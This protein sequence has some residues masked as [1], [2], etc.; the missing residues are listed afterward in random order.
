MAD[1]INI[2]VGYQDVI[3][4]DKASIKLA[5]AFTDMEKA[6]GR[7][8]TGIDGLLALA[9]K[10]ES[11]NLSL[12]QVYKSL[13]ADLNNAAKTSSKLETAYLQQNLASKS[14][15][16]SAKAMQEAFKEQESEAAKLA[17]EVENLSLKYKP[18]YAAS[19]QYETKL[20]E[21]NKAHQLGVISAKQH[22]AAIESLNKDYTAFVNGT[23]G[24]S[25]QFVQ[26][27]NRAG[28]SV[29]RFGMYAQQFGYQIGDFFVQIQS[30]TNAFVAFGQQA[31]QL[32]GLLP[33]LAGAIVGIG[34]SVGT[35]FLSMW[36]RTRKEAEETEKS[37]YNL[38]NA[39][40]NLNKVQKLASVE[41]RG[42]I[43]RAFK[44]SSS[45]VQN[46]LDRLQKLEFKALIEPV[47][48]EINQISAGVDR[49]SVAL[50]AIQGFEK[51]KSQGVELNQ[52]QGRI[53]ADAKRLVEENL[54]LALSYDT[55]KQA[56]DKISTA[57]T[58]EQLVEGFAN[59]LKVAEG[60]SG[61]VGQKLVQD[62]LDAAKEAG[63]LDEIMQK[64]SET[65]SGA[66]N[67]AN[68]LSK[69]ISDAT[70][71]ALGLRDALAS[72]SMASL[73]RQEQIASLK[74]QIN[75]AQRGAS[76]AAAKAA[77]E[78][79]QQLSK[80]GATLDQIASAAAKAG[81]EAKE[82]EKLQNTLG[83]LTKPETKSSKKSGGGS[84][85][86]TDTIGDLARSL[87]PEDQSPDIWYANALAKLQE[88][89]AME[90]EAL[91]GQ[92]NAKLLI[93]QEYQ[94]QILAL[95]EKE[96]SFTRTAAE[97]MFGALA[98]LMSTFGSESKAAAL[99]ALGINKALAIGQVIVNTAAAQTRA[100]A[101]L[102]PVAGPPVA[103]KI[104]AFGKAQAA[105]IAA[106]GLAEAVSIGKGSSGGGSSSSS[107]SSASTASST[108]SSST[109]TSSESPL[110]I[111]FAGL[112]D[113]ASY[114]G[115][116]IKELF[117][118]FYKEN[119]ARGVVF[120]VT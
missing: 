93:E 16:E 87:L 41:I 36:D 46:L 44:E 13:D 9:S 52:V 115:S 11:A 101:E 1:D 48:D 23:A 86:K 32:A 55:V 63:V 92:A 114:K 53:L 67:N 14:A 90:L 51:L 39:I 34:I 112:E 72:A 4:A 105:I 71:A 102:G 117:D 33:G 76:V 58:S 35:M 82:I 98:G 113:E 5:K 49:I 77:A 95:R 68:R 15:R 80:A 119:K 108:T 6:A 21:I 20:N 100:L 50:D 17:R 118:L 57:K 106:T 27:T 120:K 47:K 103:A 69:E 18:L 84:K 19:T 59:A 12:S 64:A 94:N 30:G 54:V 22:E 61:T 65:T 25:N 40:S 7:G 38:S 37:M 60:L 109:S 31:T 73:S 24:W 91:G 83:D 79:S 29:N 45:A 3:N 85:G 111:S 70:N 89:N 75:A 104:G 42:G 88:F 56:L 110:V 107:A 43:I 28:K 78:T 2:S 10:L 81:E 97:G 116:K 99:A 96:A 26:G 66:A 74:A 8:A 62:I